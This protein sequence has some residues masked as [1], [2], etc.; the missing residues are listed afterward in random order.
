MD[1]FLSEPLSPILMPEDVVSRYVRLFLLLILQ[2]TYL[3]PL[4]PASTI[5]LP[6]L[7]YFISFLQI[8]ILI[9]FCC[10]AFSNIA[11]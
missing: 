11:D 1:I 5:L 9:S 4:L 6:P 3:Q 2:F 10:I 8:H 7:F